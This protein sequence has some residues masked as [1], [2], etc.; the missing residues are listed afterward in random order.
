MALFNYCRVNLALRQYALIF[1]GGFVKTQW[2][3]RLGML[4][5]ATSFADP[6]AN[7]A[8]LESAQ[9]DLGQAHREFY[10]KLK[11]SK[12][13]SPENVRKLQ[14]QILTPAQSKVESALASERKRVFQDAA[15]KSKPR[16]AVQKGKL[17]AGAPVPR[18]PGTSGSSAPVQSSGTGLQPRSAPT[19][20]PALDG[21]GL[22]RIIEFGKKQEN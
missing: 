15:A 6:G 1:G 21:E 14:T 7:A 4:L 11:E 10:K 12:N 8:E 5:V 13:T 16:V 22:P 2:G 9:K 18:G 20:K 17:A 19:S 3:I